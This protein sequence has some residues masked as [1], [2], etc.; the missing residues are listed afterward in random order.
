VRRWWSLCGA[1]MSDRAGRVVYPGVLAGRSGAEALR[2]YLMSERVTGEDADFSEER[3]VARY[4][5]DLANS[6]GNLLTR[7][8]N[9]LHQY[10]NGRVSRRSSDDSRLR[11]VHTFVA[12]VLPIIYE[13]SL[14]GPAW[15]R[16][17]QISSSLA[18][19]FGGSDDDKPFSLDPK[20]NA[21]IEEMYKETGPLRALP[22][23][24]RAI[25]ATEPWKLAKGESNKD[26]L[27]ALLYYLAESLR[28]VA[29]LISPVLP[30]AA[31]GIFD[32]L[33][34]KMELCG[35]EERFSLKD[36]EWGDLPDGHVVGKPVP[37][38]PRIEL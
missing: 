8:L 37:L 17:Y 1:N 26:L 35:K 6:L 5:A 34:W 32:Q 27:D 7:S 16:E 30:K 33:N 25:E 28:I 38:F 4:N 22:R 29:I 31:H 15:P 11:Y 18:F 19:I 9:M 24:N 3:L 21:Q 23:C 12:K 14:V 20:L 13:R 10:R 36:V 2:Y